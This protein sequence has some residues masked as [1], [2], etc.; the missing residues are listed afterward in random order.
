MNAPR[1][2]ADSRASQRTTTGLQVTLSALG[3]ALAAS[4]TAL[5]A[6]SFRMARTVVRPAGRRPDTRIVRL[7][8]AAQTISLE[9]TPNTTLPGRYGLFTVGS[10]EYLRLGSIVGEDGT[11]VTRK[12]LTHVPADGDLAPEAAFS[13]WYFDKP[14][15][16][17]LPFRSLDIDTGVGACPAWEF[18]AERD[19]DVWV[20][21]V[22]GRGTTRSE[23][24]R[25]VPVFH[26]L[27][28]SSL[29][30]SYRNDGDAPRSP[31]G[32]YALGATEWRDVDA[33]I[34]YARR[35]GARHV[36][37]MGWSM[38]G[39]LSLQAALESPH[40]DVIAGLVLD[41]PV[42]DWRTVL[43]FQGRAMRLPRPVIALAERTL[44]STWGAT[45][46]RSGE[47]IPLDRLDA[48]SRAAELRHPVLILHSDDDG[49][50]PSDA[51]HALARAR[52]DLVTMET[53]TV[54]RHTKLWNYDEMRW[55]TAIRD[56]VR[57]QGLSRE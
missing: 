11:T 8:A 10:V 16:L 53:F 22:H 19:S 55:T 6:V 48:V 49:F 42:A 37:L 13:G 30:V 45:A 24:L 20:V 44:A 47:P 38:G 25:A 33:A 7:D 1:R 57:R 36:L 3:V 17:L 12:L 50:V 46:L 35:R 40:T 15:D 54:A 56:W 4:A 52:P 18:P 41:S 5:G 43:T 32:T 51:S 27:G 14:D 9:R 23:T 21:Q 31:S 29:V 26:A 28:I 34:G 2:A 39:A